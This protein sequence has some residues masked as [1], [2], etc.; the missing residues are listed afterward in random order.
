MLARYGAF[1]GLLTAGLTWPEAACTYC[2]YNGVAASYIFTN[3]ALSHTHLPV[4]E[5]DSYLHWVEYAARHTTNIEAGPICNWWMS[6]LNF[7]IEHHLF[8]S[9]PQF[10]H[11]QVSLKVKALFEKHGLHYDVRP[12]FSCLGETLYNM[13]KVGQSAGIASKPKKA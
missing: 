3:F 4:T 6:N 11:P 7:Q 9:M 1:F 2:V 5:A 10:R 8:P 13:H 12:Y